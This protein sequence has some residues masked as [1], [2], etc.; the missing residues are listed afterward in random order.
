MATKRKTAKK[1][2]NKPKPTPKPAPKKRAAP[3]ARVKRKNTKPKEPQAERRATPKARDFRA[4]TAK[5]MAVAFRGHK[6]SVTPS[7]TPLAI[8]GAI[9]IGL[10]A[11]KQA[12]ANPAKEPKPEKPKPPV[13]IPVLTP[14]EPPKKLDNGVSLATSKKDGKTIT[15][16]AS[17]T[18]YKRSTKPPI[19]AVKAANDAITAA[20]GKDAK[21]LVGEIFASRDNWLV[22]YEQHY[23]PDKGV[24]LGAT[25]YERK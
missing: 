15:T 23:W 5:Q 19:S 1:V 22:V 6:A 8:I 18:G 13:E 11:I 14:P 4:V 7:A 20:K 17:I 16:V 3:K 24:H 10:F 12:S 9:A 21:N 25:V 2:V